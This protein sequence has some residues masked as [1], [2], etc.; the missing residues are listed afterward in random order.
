MMISATAL[1]ADSGDE[2]R[3]VFEDSTAQ[4]ERLRVL[5]FADRC[6]RDHFRHR[7]DRHR[8]DGSLVKS[9]RL[10]NRDE[11]GVFLMIGIMMQPGMEVRNRH[12]HQGQQQSRNDR[13]D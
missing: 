6:R 13:A 8:D 2:R 5:H 1:T 11:A 3:S 4:K 10:Q 9:A 7:H 12:Q